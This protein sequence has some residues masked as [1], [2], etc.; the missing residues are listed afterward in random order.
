MD[1]LSSHATK[2]PAVPLTAALSK[3]LLDSETS[4][5]VHTNG[6]RHA[7]YPE[8]WEVY[9][10][11][12]GCELALVA[13]KGR[14]CQFDLHNLDQ[15]ITLLVVLEGT[16]KLGHNSHWVCDVPEGQV[17]LIMPC[18]GD[19]QLIL[20]ESPQH[21]ALLMDLGN[22][23]L[24]TVL[25]PEELSRLS[26]QL[27]RVHGSQQSLLNQNLP[28][29][30]PIY[31]LVYNLIQS[32]RTARFRQMLVESRA[33]ELAATILQD[34]LT[35]TQFV[36][37]ANM[38]IELIRSI[39]KAHQIVIENFAS[40]P[41]LTQL[42]RRVGVNRNKLSRGFKTLYGATVFEY[43]H[44]YRMDLAQTL[45]KKSRHSIAHVAELTGYDHPGNFTTAYK[46]HYGI[47]PKQSRTV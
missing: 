33:N 26:R 23:F 1:Y 43:C 4:T 28:L 21:V 13:G 44:N 12:N 34:L 46:R 30:N 32:P 31:N 41:T 35:H 18:T 11:L 36:G 37:E 19:L 10:V 6:T 16:I 3:H 40:P 15:A 2:T 9:R 27:C 42:S 17:T 25:N 7:S 20:D 47:L 5:P 38:P 14:H 45:L 22:R 29:T 24:T 8:P 39:Q